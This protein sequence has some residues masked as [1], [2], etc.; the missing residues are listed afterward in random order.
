MTGL[1]RVY[2]LLIELAKKVEA[3]AKVE[4][5]KNT[6]A[7][8]FKVGQDAPSTTACTTSRSKAEAQVDSVR[9]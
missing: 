9:K 1:T 4:A 3:E 5:Q 7:S 8:N 6:T 2:E